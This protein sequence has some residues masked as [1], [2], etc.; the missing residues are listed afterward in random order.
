MKSEIFCW[1]SRDSVTSKT[2]RKVENLGQAEKMPQIQR[3]LKIMVKL[4]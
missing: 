4:L 1:V 3:S 2:G